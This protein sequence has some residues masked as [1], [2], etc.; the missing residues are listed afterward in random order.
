MTEEQCR[1]LE[2]L[3]QLKETNG[4]VEK[5]THTIFNLH[6]EDVDFAMKNGYLQEDIEKP[7][8]TL[9]PNQTLGTAFMFFAR[10]CLLGDSVGL[11][12]TVQLA[13]LMNIS[14][15]EA[16]NLFGRTA[17]FRYLVLTEKPLVEE[18][19]AK[20][21]KFTGEYVEKVFG[22]K[23]ST[24]KF[25]ERVNDY[26]FE[27]G[28]VASHSLFNQV[29]FHSWLYELS[30]GDEVYE[31]FDYIIVDES[32]VLGN[33]KTKMYK[34]AMELRKYSK[35]VILLNAQPFE[36]KLDYMY[37]QL[38]YIDPTCL[39][40]KGAFEKEYYV[41]DYTKGYPIHNGQYKNAD[42][43]KFLTSYFYFSQTRQQLGAEIVNVKTF[44]KTIPL[45]TPQRRLMKE[46]QMY[47]MIYD[48]PTVI[49]NSVPFN[50]ETTP[51]L[52]LLR[53]ILDGELILKG[54]QILI[55]VHYKES[56]K[57]LKKWL[58]EKGYETEI[59]NGEVTNDARYDIITR[60]KKNRFQVLITNVQKG[61]DFGS[62][63]HVIFYAYMP[64]PSKMIQLE[65]RVTRDFDIKD[66]NFF[67]LATE[68]RELDTIN[69]TLSRLYQ[70]SSAFSSKDVSAIG[71]LLAA[72]ME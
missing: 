69:T 42:N 25:T 40:N 36:S 56:H 44:L 13:S 38:N 64:N 26:L 35:N 1:R 8:G 43:F 6:N 72:E 17:T 7:L 48:V 29:D 52:K 60:F 45:S 41:Y 3:I 39:P 11:G 46:S 23:A 57:Y 71:Q 24:R 55:S 5:L 70:H 68:D 27:G 22:D 28:I 54:E 12:K 53:E 9:K 32:S 15:R 61:L 65:G 18:T 37:G 14:K 58:T 51:K 62:V 34:N 2:T 21:I 16:V 30:E 63:K 20:L 10:N 31:Y 59:L 49:D 66:K 67:L 4:S 50:E 47:R 33:T 19:Q